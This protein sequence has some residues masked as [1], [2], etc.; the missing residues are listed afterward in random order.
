MEGKCVTG[1]IRYVSIN[2]HLGIEQS[3]RDDLEAIGYMLIYLFK[4]RL[5][6]M[7]VK[8]DTITQR[9]QIIGSIKMS[10]P[11]E[12]LIEEMPQ[13]YNI[14]LSATRALQFDEEPDYMQFGNM[15]INLLAKK[16]ALELNDRIYD[17]NRAHE[18]KDP[19][20]RAL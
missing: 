17:W 16:Y 5:P 20:L 1:T 7:N 18:I 8:A 14:F 19:I 3:R 4:G 9:Y 13:E 2:N 6:W 11:I 10:T 15:F 12:E